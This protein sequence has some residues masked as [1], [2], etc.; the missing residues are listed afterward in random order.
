MTNNTLKLYNLMLENKEIAD[1]IVSMKEEE[2]LN[3]SVAVLA[4]FGLI[5]GIIDKMANLD[6]LTLLSSN[7]LDT[8]CKELFAFKNYFVNSYKGINAYVIYDY[9]KLEYQNLFTLVKKILGI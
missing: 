2:F 5:N 8:K 1:E 3:N 7:E 4:G 6:Y 9:F